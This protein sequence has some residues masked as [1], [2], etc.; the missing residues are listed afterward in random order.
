[1]KRISVKRTKNPVV[2]LLLMTV[3]VLFLAGCTNKD[4]SPAN[5]DTSNVNQEK[6]SPQTN[7]PKVENEQITGTPITEE[8]VVAEPKV[9]ERLPVWDDF[10]KKYGTFYSAIQIEDMFFYPGMMGAELY[11]TIENSADVLIENI[12]QTMLLEADEG[13]FLQSDETTK[14][15]YMRGGT[16]WFYDYFRNHTGDLAALSD[17]I[18]S[19]VI[20]TKEAIPYCRFFDGTYTEASLLQ[21]SYSG[22]EQLAA[23][24]ESYS[25]NLEKDGYNIRI[26]SP[27][28]Y[29]MASLSD[30]NLYYTRQ[31][32]TMFLEV[33]ATTGL[34]NNISVEAL[35]SSD[36]MI[37]TCVIPTEYKWTEGN[38]K[39]VLDTF[40][41]GNPSPSIVNADNAE[42]IYLFRAGEV[43]TFYCFVKSIPEGE[44][45]PVYVGAELCNYGLNYN[46]EFVPLEYYLS[47]YVA[48]S[49][50][51]PSYFDILSSYKLYPVE[52]YNIELI[53]EK[54]SKDNL[55]KE[56]TSFEDMSEED[57]AAFIDYA[58]YFMPPY[59]HMSSPEVASV[60]FDEQ[61]E[62]ESS[63]LFILKTVSYDK[64]YYYVVSFNMPYYNIELQQYEYRYHSK[65]D[66][67]GGVE[68]ALDVYS[69][70]DINS[71][72]SDYKDIPREI[73]I[74]INEKYGYSLLPLS[75]L[76]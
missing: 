24:L 53:Y 61:S 26:T 45:S 68:A 57:I 30:E 55:I 39:Q 23:L 41:S 8:P 27:D 52:S 40:L 12:V 21:I 1:M 58:F 17:C 6:D 60:V 32:S 36:C 16:P 33:N 51:Q 48:Y 42:L 10:Y 46:N 56:F 35:S 3:I 62:N 67:R 2:Q 74:N 50:P 64:Y 31:T 28:I 19:L 65:T 4:V 63:L 43:E 59:S 22:V 71:A 49:E 34:L 76:K 72:T 14:L 5:K 66:T 11:S 69:V 13:A 20:P 18:V 37:Y 9:Y 15:T 75:E 70:Y 44:N 7:I 38:L 73:L 25:Y 29:S 54:M 47:N